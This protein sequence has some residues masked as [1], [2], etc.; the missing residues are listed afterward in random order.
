[1]RY[2]LARIAH[3]EAFGKRGFVERNGRLIP[4]SAAVVGDRLRG[5]RVA[6][7]KKKTLPE[8]LERLRPVFE[9]IGRQVSNFKPINELF[10]PRIVEGKSAR[11]K[12]KIK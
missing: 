8:A 1:M 6:P 9:Q 3:N 7:P 2:L 11:E 5:V 12:E 4:A 10:L